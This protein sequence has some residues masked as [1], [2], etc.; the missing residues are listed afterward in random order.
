MADEN[1][2][3]PA[4]ADNSAPDTQ[5]QA[6][7]VETT[8]HDDKSGGDT[9]LEDAPDGK[10]PVVHDWPDDW[11]DKFA[12][13]DDKT[14]KRLDRFKSP[15]DVYK[16]WQSMEQK[17][18]SGETVAKLGEDASDDEIA[19]YREANGIPDK[20]DGYLESLPNGLVIGDDDKP[21][22]DSYLESVHGL[23][24][25]PA[26]VAKSLDWYYAQQE[27]QVAAQSL[28]DKEYRSAGVE[29]LRAEWG[30]EF[31]GNL[32]SAMSFLDTAPVDGDG[33]SLKDNL[34]GARLADGTLLGDNPSA[35]RWLTGLANDANPAGFVSPGS[36][37]SQADSVDDH[38]AEIEKV[39]RTDRSAYNKD[40]KMQGRYLKL[41]GAREKLSAS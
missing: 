35:L 41:L 25:D 36:G 2:V 37:M 18:S 31:K 15:A 10:A 9:I 26:I 28:A 5:V 32:N 24:A 17:M 33:V 16:S 8:A 38:I 13:D 7:Q 12:G 19:A 39:M 30:A 14:R 21:M 23:N 27:E 11:R 20:P 34:L 29:E 4:D 3:D 6:E 1:V 22:V 40:E